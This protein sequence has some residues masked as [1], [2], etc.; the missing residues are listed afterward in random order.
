MYALL[1]GGQISFDVFP[2]GWDKRYCLQYLKK[3]GIKNIHFFGDKTSPVNVQSCVLERVCACV[4][5]CERILSVSQCLCLHLIPHHYIFSPI[6]RMFSH[7]L[8]ILFSRILQMPFSATIKCTFLSFSKLS[9]LPNAFPS[10]SSSQPHY[11]CTIFMTFSPYMCRIPCL[12]CLP[13]SSYFP[14]SFILVLSLIIFLYPHTFPHHFPLSSYF[15]SSF[16]F[17]LI[18]L[19]IIFLYPHT[20][21]HHF[22][23]SSYFPSSVSFILILSL[24]IFLYPHT[25]PHPFPLS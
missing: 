12:P 14:S 6:L 2:E 7:I 3:D 4:R 5:V 13:L 1:A 16:S 24:I 10:K 17:I 11:L 25:F 23:L 21:P 20:F 8:Q 15:P 18:I 19:L 22:P 9:S